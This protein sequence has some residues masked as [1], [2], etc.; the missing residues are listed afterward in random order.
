MHQPRETSARP[1]S[2]CVASALPGAGCSTTAAGLAVS[3]CT[4][5]LTVVLDL[6]SRPLSPWPIALTRR[7][8]AGFSIGSPTVATIHA[9]TSRRGLMD[10]AGAGFDVLTDLTSPA[11]TNARPLAWWRDA[12]AASG[13]ETAIADLGRPL[14]G[15]PGP[16]DNPCPVSCGVL[17][18]VVP[19]TRPGTAAATRLVSGWEDAG[20]TTD[21]VVIA[22][23]A[24]APGRWD[25]RVLADLTMLQRRTAATVHLPYDRVLHREGLAGLDRM[26]NPARRAFRRLAAVT[27]DVSATAQPAAQPAVTTRTPMEV[28]T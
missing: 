8:D 24:R 5:G 13:W 27:V 17:V 26:G 2:I 4:Q 3:L 23:L 11:V 25:G 21:Q 20:R 22:A 14:L 19:G 15:P 12:V 9:L 6:A 7:A 1:T 28:S 10:P 18:L 16:A